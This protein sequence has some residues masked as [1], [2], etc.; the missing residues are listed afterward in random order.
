MCVAPSDLHCTY[1]C[2]YSV[3][4]QYVT[5][6]AILTCWTEVGSMYIQM[7]PLRKFRGPHVHMPIKGHLMILFTMHVLYFL[8]NVYRSSVLGEV[9]S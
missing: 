9:W 6:S 8:G 4:M 7:S 2:I 3:Q 1:I 5:P